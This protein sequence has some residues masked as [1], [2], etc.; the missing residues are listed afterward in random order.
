MAIPRTPK[1]PVLPS[2]MEHGAKVLEVA[3][4]PQLG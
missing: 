3:Q 2:A 1:T 4:W